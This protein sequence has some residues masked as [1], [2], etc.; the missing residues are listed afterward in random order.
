MSV[1]R[2]RCLEVV[3]GLEVAVSVAARGKLRGRGQPVLG[4]RTL[5]RRGTAWRFGSRL[6]RVRDRKSVV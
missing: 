1:F 3:S 6:V 2:L 5:L 4:W